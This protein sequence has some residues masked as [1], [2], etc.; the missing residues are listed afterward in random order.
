MSD[1]FVDLPDLDEV[2]GMGALPGLDLDDIDLSVGT[3]SVES[4]PGGVASIGELL[5]GTAM[6]T[7]ELP[8]LTANRLE[9]FVESV[10]SI[11]DVPPEPK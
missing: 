9:T 8:S 3:V 1:P 11:L 4:G 10:M 7:D 6:E 5:A 2:P